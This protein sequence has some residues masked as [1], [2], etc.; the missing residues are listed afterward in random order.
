MDKE[1]EVVKEEM[2]EQVLRRRRRPTKEERTW[3]GERRDKKLGKLI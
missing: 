3:K 2:E 1:G